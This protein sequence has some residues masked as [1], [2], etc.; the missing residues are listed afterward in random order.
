MKNCCKYVGKVYKN[1]YCTVSTS[2][3]GSLIRHAIVFHNTKHVTSHK[4]QQAALEKKRNWKHKQGTVIGINEVWHHILKYPE[5]ITNLT[6]VIIQTALLE[7]V[8]GKPLQNPDNIT[9]KNFTQYDA[10]VTHN[11]EK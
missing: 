2:A 11:S 8:T 10:N 6:F 4:L 9:N 1:N 7:T 3:Y 5:V